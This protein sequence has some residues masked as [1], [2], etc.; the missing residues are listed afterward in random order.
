MYCNNKDWYT[1]TVLLHKDLKLLQSHDIMSLFHLV[2]VYQQQNMCGLCAKLAV[3]GSDSSSL[4]HI[5]NRY[6]FD[7]FRVF[8]QTDL[9]RPS[10]VEAS[11]LEMLKTG[12]IRDFV[13]WRDEVRHSTG[14]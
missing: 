8:E 1:P 3:C 2:F 11:E 7:T 4:N 6:R 12:S 14:N 13:L 5:A 9:I 10:P